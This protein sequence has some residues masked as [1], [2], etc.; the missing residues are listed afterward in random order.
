MQCCEALEV[1]GVGGVS[2]DGLMWNVAA[3]EGLWGEK[4]ETRVLKSIYFGK[5]HINTEN[6]DMFCNDY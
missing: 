4:K 6:S 5:C 2:T 3:P 1:N